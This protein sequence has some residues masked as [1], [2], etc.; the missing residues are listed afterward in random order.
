MATNPIE[1]RIEPSEN[2]EQPIYVLIVDVGQSPEVKLA[3]SETYSDKAG[4]RKMI[5]ALVA[6]SSVTYHVFQGANA[7]EKW[8]WNVKS[9]NGLRLAR[10]AFYYGTQTRAHARADFLKANAAGGKIVDN[11]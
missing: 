2:S 7:A 11:A 6:G 4:A 5:A 9:T 10:G 3:Y 8:Y 1:Y